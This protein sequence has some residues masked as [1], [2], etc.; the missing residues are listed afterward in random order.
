MPHLVFVY[1][2]LMKG[3]LHHTSIQ[4]ARFV[5]TAETLPAYE[6]VQIDYY[7]AMIAGGTLAIH[8]ELYE[9]D[10]QTLAKLDELEEVP[11]YYERSEIQL[12]DGTRALTYIMPRERAHPSSLPIPSGHFRLRTQPPK[13]PR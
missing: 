13:K 8:G 5:R 9:V 1:G 6:L 4:H 11:T 7:P 10:D 3:E 2:T 12:A